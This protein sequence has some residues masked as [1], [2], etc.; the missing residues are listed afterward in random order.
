MVYGLTITAMHEIEYISPVDYTSPTATTI[1]NTQSDSQLLEV[2]S[3]GEW[4]CGRG[5][6][7]LRLIYHRRTASSIDTMH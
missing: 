4:W 2:V 1:V 7:Y 6:V 3:G 5:C